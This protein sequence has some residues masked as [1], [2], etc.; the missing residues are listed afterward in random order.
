M[1]LRSA[2][3]LRNEAVEKQARQIA[4][5][6]TTR[7]TPIS[8]EIDVA[9]GGVK[10]WDLSP[11]VTDQSPDPTEPP[12]RPAPVPICTTPPEIIGGTPQAGSTLATTGGSW[13]GATPAYSYA[14]RRNGVNVAGA[15]SQTYVLATAPTPPRFSRNTMI[16]RGRGPSPFPWCSPTR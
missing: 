13:T 2:L 6:Q 16:R 9:V 10:Q 11:I 8:E 3:V 4:E 7:P 5:F 14:W 12:G 15:T 1:D